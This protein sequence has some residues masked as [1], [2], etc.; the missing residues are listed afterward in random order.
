MTDHIMYIGKDMFGKVKEYIGFNF[1][2]AYADFKDDVKVY[3]NIHCVGR[4]TFEH[5]NQIKYYSKVNR[6][7]E[8]TIKPNQTFILK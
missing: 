5:K 4:Q 8:L 3:K 2:G 6:Q 7:L 1:R